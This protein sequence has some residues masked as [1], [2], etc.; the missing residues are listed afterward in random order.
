MD[1]MMPQMDGI[2]TTQKLREL[3]YSGVIVAL[4]ANAL[5]G[6]DELFAKNGFNGFIPKPVDVRQL[7]SILNKF[8]RD[9]HQ[10]ESR[11]SLAQCPSDPIKPEKKLSPRLIQAFQTD[12][13]RAVSFLREFLN[14]FSM[15]SADSDIKL[16]ITTVH[17]MKSVLANVGED[18]ASAQASE[19]ENAGQRGDTDFITANTE[20][21]IETL[22]SLLKTIVN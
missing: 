1:H 2:E 18:T 16:F 4:T 10:E 13:Q 17:A 21:F 5:V 3:G 12:T 11:V 20:A 15:P 19:L 6:N 14:S 8:V 9:R 7:N 22:E